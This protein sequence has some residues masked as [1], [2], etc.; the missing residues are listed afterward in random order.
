MTVCTP[1]V[2]VDLPLADRW[3]IDWPISGQSDTATAAVE[4][5]ASG[6]WHSLVISGGYASGYF[7]GPSFVTPGLAV[8]VPVT[9][10]CLIQVIDGPI[11]ITFDGG[12]IRLV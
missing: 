1:G 9:S 3:Y 6:T 10:H 2:V 4:L 7:A 11:T 8:V 5:E 12:F